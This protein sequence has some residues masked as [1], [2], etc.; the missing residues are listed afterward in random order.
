ML[1][2]KD[3]GGV[4]GGGRRIPYKKSW[5]D[6]SFPMP[7]QE[8]TV[9]SGAD[10]YGIDV[11]SDGRTVWLGDST[12]L[13]KFVDYVKVVQVLGLIYLPNPIIAVGSLLIAYFN[14]SY[15]YFSAYRASDGS[16]S[17]SGFKSTATN[18]AKIWVNYARNGFIID[19]FTSGITSYT[20]SGETI[21]QVT[22]QGTSNPIQRM[23]SLKTGN[24]LVTTRNGFVYI[25][26]PDLSTLLT[27]SGGT[28]SASDYIRA[29]ASEKFNKCYIW[30]G[31]FVYIH[32]LTTGT[33]ISKF[34]VPSAGQNAWDYDFFK[35]DLKGYIHVGMSITTTYN[36]YKPDGTLHVSTTIPV[37]YRVY[38]EDNNGN[39]WYITSKTAGKLLLTV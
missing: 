17:L 24:Y 31:A 16:L 12:R 34:S 39:P 19:D 33:F 7:P 18:S 2:L 29:D 23:V 13:T 30:A 6:Y 1:S 22:S 10:L 4:Y 5:V 36:I 20:V 11:S 25:M 37:D 32:N 9:S 14:S 8:G 38:R 27:M 28:W 21:T 15:K 3:H 26:K 35:V